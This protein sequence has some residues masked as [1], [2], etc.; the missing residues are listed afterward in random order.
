MLYYRISRKLALHLFDFIFGT[1]N[2]LA[3]LL[4]VLTKQ[5][6]IKTFKATMPRHFALKS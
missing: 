5:I 1:G 2:F 4:S 3:F 6:A